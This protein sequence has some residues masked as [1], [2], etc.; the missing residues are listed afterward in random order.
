M[1]RSS[2]YATL[3]RG[4]Y[5]IAESIWILGIISCAGFVHEF[6]LAMQFF[7]IDDNGF[8]SDIAALL[9]TD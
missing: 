2:K 6:F 8:I 7:V 3:Y 1:S 4:T 5:N 9:V